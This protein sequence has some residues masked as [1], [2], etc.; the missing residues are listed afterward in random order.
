LP[1]DGFLTGAIMSVIYLHRF[2]DGERRAVI[3][4]GLLIALAIADWGVLYC[5]GKLEFDVCQRITVERFSMAICLLLPYICLGISF[6]KDSIKAC[7]KSALNVIYLLGGI[8][9]FIAWIWMGD[10]CRALFWAIS[11]YAMI[12]IL[13]TFWEENIKEAVVLLRNKIHVI[14]PF[15]PLFLVYPLVIYVFVLLKTEILY[16]EQISELAQKVLEGLQK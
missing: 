7:E 5:N 3:Y 8:P 11:Y 1:Y 6:F 12:F 15:S 9:G 10:Y 14:C 13:L 4:L 16:D 2:F